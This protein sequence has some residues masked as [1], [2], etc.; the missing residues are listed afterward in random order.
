MRATRNPLHDPTLSQALLSGVIELAGRFQR[1]HGRKPV[2]ME[3]CGSHTM[4]LARSGLKKSLKDH[5]L[6]VS[7]PGCPVCV[8]DQQTIDAMIAVAE[9]DG[10]IICTF[11]DM[12]RV[13]GSGGNLLQAKARGKDIRIVYGPADAVAIAERNPDKEVVF[14]GIGF[15]TTV[16]VLGAAMLEAENKGLRN[17]S[18]WLSAKQ[19][20]PVLRHLLNLREVVLDGFLLPGHVAMIVGSDYFEFLP[21]EYGMSGVI[22]G[23]EPVELARGIYRLLELALSGQPQIVNDHPSVVTAGGNAVAQRLV[24]TLFEACEDQWRG[25][26]PIEASGLALRP[27][28]RRLDAKARFPVEVKPTA[29]TGCRCGEVIRGVITPSECGLFGKACTPHQPVGPCMVSAEGSCSADY[30]YVREG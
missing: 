25:I 13:P 16:P 27:E 30:S 22:S 9:G 23:F 7:G 18:M 20:E 10:R 14:L 6:L 12:M 11:G 15:E 21:K 29:P 24:A 19:V 17:F 1:Q 8:T 5:V 4:A 2:F 28:Y 3:V 26:G